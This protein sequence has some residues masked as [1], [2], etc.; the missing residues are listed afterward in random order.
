MVLSLNKAAKLDQNFDKHEEETSQR[1][2][3]TFNS[4]LSAD[5]AAML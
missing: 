1:G 4:K 5:V 3:P 2:E